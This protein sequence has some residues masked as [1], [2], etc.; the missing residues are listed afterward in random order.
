[1]SDNTPRR[2]HRL[3]LA[4]LAG[5]LAPGFAQAQH[6]ANVPTHPRD[7]RLVHHV[8]QDA[9]Q[10]PVRAPISFKFGT[11]DYPD[12]PDSD[13]QAINDKNIIVGTYGGDLPDFRQ[14]LPAYGFLLKSGSFKKIVYPK[15]PITLPFGL[16]SSGEV[17]GYYSLDPADE[18]GHGFTL[19]G[20]KFTT[21][22]YP[23]GVQYTFL[24][25]INKSGQIVGLYSFKGDNDS[26]GFLLKAGVFTDIVY[27]GSA[28]TFPYGIDDAGDIV[29][30]YTI[31]NVTLHGFTLVSGVYSNVD[32]SGATDTCLLGLNNKGQMVGY[33]DEGS[34]TIAH[35]FLWQSGTFTAFDVPYAGVVT[36]WPF[37]INDSGRIVGQYWDS[38]N[39]TFG[40]EAKIG[41]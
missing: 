3:L 38:N 37:A 41:K 33:Y 30:C 11:V 7:G 25:S 31:D 34:G 9:Q 8:T 14:G 13:A 10:P 29:G 21:V 5:L 18:S 6:T 17:V 35:G 16:N 4:L 40:F 26:H 36:T 19:V 12:G 23:G 1:M 39:Y 2:Q 22:D 27:P 20:N 28:G 32:Y 15:A 24:N